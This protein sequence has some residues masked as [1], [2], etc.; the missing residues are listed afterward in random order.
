MAGFHQE[1]R[2]VAPAPQEPAVSALT[3]YQTGFRWDEPIPALAAVLIA[4]QR[5]NHATAFASWT[6][7]TI[8]LGL[9]FQARTV[10]TAG[11]VP[12]VLLTGLLLPVLAM[13][14]RVTVLLVYAGRAGAGAAVGGAWRG[15]GDP[16]TGA[17][18]DDPPAAGLVTSVLPPG[19]EAGAELGSAEAADRLRLLT[20]A[21]QRREVL[22][23]AALNWAYAAGV[24]FL[25][26]S[27]LTT[28]LSAGA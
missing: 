26:W 27:F 3:G 12:A 22:A 20:A 16:S 19:G 5:A 2:R 10:W 13:A 17:A 28:L 23:H 1:E 8:G 15:A 4:L 24:A 25:A 7:T 9:I 21:V 11:S 14:A 6:V 18:A